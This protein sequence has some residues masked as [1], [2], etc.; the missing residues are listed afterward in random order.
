MVDYCD[1]DDEDEFHWL[2]G[3]YLQKEWTIRDL[4]A[5]KI[6]PRDRTVRRRQGRTEFRDDGLMDKRDIHG[7]QLPE[8]RP[9]PTPPQPPSLYSLCHQETMEERDPDKN[10]KS[11][12]KIAPP[13]GREL[14]ANNK[15][16][17][18]PPE[19]R[20]RLMKPG[21]QTYRI[22]KEKAQL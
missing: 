18:P 7:E 6:F 14:A 16:E 20:S 13:V 4:M 10:W 2:E 11:N 19:S 1:G 15:A 3:P 5:Q 17:G 8:F 22:T 21:R 12:L 9:R